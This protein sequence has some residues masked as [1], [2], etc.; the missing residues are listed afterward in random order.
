MTNFLKSP[1]KA[2]LLL[3]LLVL[4]PFSFS[5]CK[6]K[7]DLPTPNIQ[8][9]ADLVHKY[10]FTTSEPVK[11]ALVVTSG[12]DDIYINGI[13]Q[14]SGLISGKEFTIDGSATYELKTKS[15]VL[16]SS[17]VLS[18]ISDESDKQ[19]VVKM[20]WSS[21]VNGRADQSD[22]QTY[23]FEDLVNGNNYDTSANID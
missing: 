17:F 19:I 14:K 23:T 9:K 16:L 2:F 7:G 8:Q 10:T 18:R 5:S 13:N 20:T 4:L 1:T 12:L 6:N 11:V 21:S 15:T 3:S 22:T